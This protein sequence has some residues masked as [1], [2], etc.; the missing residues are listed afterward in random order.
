MKTFKM[1]LPGG[2]FPNESKECSK[3]IQNFI[4]NFKS[5]LKNH[6]GA[7]VPHAGWDF[8]GSITAKV[9]QVLS[10]RDVQPDVVCIIGGHLAQYHPVLFLVYDEA[11]S[12]L[13]NIL[14]NRDLTN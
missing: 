8:S 9:F 1:K 4:K 11:V 6:T 12:P 14:F 7:V 13:G 5:D 3:E 10:N 2:W